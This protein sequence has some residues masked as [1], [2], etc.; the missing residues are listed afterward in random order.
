MEGQQAATNAG[1]HQ[2]SGKRTTTVRQDDH[3]IKEAAIK[4]RVA[5]AVCAFGIAGVQTAVERT[6]SVPVLGTS[7]VR[8]AFWIV[9]TGAPVRR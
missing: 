4:F 8:V 6:H 9:K 7:A 3:V 1:T 2:D 5:K